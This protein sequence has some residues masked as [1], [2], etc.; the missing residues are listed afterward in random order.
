MEERVGITGMMPVEVI[1]NAGF[2]PLDLRNFF[3]NHP[4]RDKLVLRAEM[5]GYPPRAGILEKGI[6]GA[7]LESK[8]DRV[9]VVFQNGPVNSY[10]LEEM[11]K[12]QGI[13]VHTFYFPPD[14]DSEILELEIRKLSSELG[15]LDLHNLDY[16]R[17]RLEEVRQ[18]ARKVDQLTWSANI[19]SGYENHKYLV[20]ASDFEGDPDIYM[21]KL[22]NFLEEL[23]RAKELT[24]KIRLGLVGDIPMCPEIY[25]VVEK[26]GARI[27]FNEPQRQYTMPRTGSDIVEQYIQFTL[28]YSPQVR[29]EDIQQAIEERKIAGVL[30]CINT[31][32]D[33]FVRDIYFRRSISVPVFSY[34]EGD[35][36]VLDGRTIM[37]LVDFI[38]GLV[39]KAA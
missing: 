32:G 36:F 15:V 33:G 34:E 31:H 17:F 14:R 5:D 6:Y 25:K 8:V 10:A 26:C 30:H 1:F 16:W 39:S 3:L 27:V 19:V 29:I 21:N 37:R 2:V 18:L 11:L 38:N 24:P 20:S 28:P 12:S 35:S 9:V 7:A 23:R 4:D 13:E 22:Y